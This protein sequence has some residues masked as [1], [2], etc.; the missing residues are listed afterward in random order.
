MGGESMVV[1]GVIFDAKEIDECG[2]RGRLRLIDRYSCKLDSRDET[3][4]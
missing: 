4:F 1:T 2:E 3:M